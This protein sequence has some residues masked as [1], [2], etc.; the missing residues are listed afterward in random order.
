MHAP[1]GNA[2]FVILIEL[3]KSGIEITSKI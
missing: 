1:V 2:Y 3:K